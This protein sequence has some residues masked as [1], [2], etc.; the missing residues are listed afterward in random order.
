MMDLK[1]LPET[2]ASLPPVHT[3]TPP[4]CGDMDLVIKANGEWIHEGGKIKRP[5]MVTMFSR[6]LWFEKGEYFLVT[7]VEKVRI[8]VEDA[9]F[10]V[11]GWQW[12]DSELGKAIEFV[13]HTDDRLV[14]GVGCDLW[15]AFFQNEERPYVSMRYGLKALVG[16]NVFYD[17]AEYLEPVKTS[18]GEGIGLISAG[19]SY[20]L[21]KDE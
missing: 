19:K 3:W 18:E 2:T 7:P 11:V 20:L 14:L 6:I 13:T 9:P 5:A 12:V 1:G 10:L 15:M 4:F 21:M 8:Q 16:R 17:L